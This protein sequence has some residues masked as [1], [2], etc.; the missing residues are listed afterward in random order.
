MH[1]NPEDV[2]PPLRTSNF[3]TF[4]FKFDTRIIART[5]YS[6]QELYASILTEV[7]PSLI[8]QTVNPIQKQLLELADTTDLGSET[9]YGLAKRLKVNHPYKV[10]FALDQLEKNGHIFRNRKTGSITKATGDGR[11]GG[12]IS[13]PFY[14]EVNCGEALSFADDMIKSFLQVSPSVIK[15]KKLSKLFA[16]KAVGWSMNRADIDGREVA[17]G[18]FVLAEKIEASEVRNGDY[19][20]S[21]IGGAANLKRF[22]KDDLES[23][24]IL[25]SESTYEYPPIII[26]SQDADEISMYQPVA[27]AIEVIPGVNIKSDTTL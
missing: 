18:D 5:I 8:L 14:G 7:R 21:L 24:I 10:K 12:L 4:C 15:T 6:V 13:V 1:S 2:D 23:R 3:T 25:M 19:V 11:F 26:S 17:D 16:L 22:Y 20:I 27:R 9:Y